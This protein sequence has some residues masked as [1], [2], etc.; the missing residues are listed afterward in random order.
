MTFTPEP[1]KDAA[2]T[3]WKRTGLFTPKTVD[4]KEK[5]SVGTEKVIRL[6][7]PR[8]W[9]PGVARAVEPANGF[10]SKRN[11][12]ALDTEVMERKTDAKWRLSRFMVLPPEGTYT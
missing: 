4:S 11:T 7:P 10:V 2:K 9:R 12:A 3:P 6:S 8:I 1:G 5:R